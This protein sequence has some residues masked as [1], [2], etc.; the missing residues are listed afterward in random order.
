MA[1]LLDVYAAFGEARRFCHG[2]KITLGQAA[3][4]ITLMD[5]TLD[6]EP[7]VAFTQTFA[8]AHLGLQVATLTRP[9]ANMVAAGWL[10]KIPQMVD[11]RAK[12]YRLTPQGIALAL[13]LRDWSADG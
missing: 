11:R 10:K 9:L 3:I 8:A 6:K 12:E 7:N 1:D 5:S 13:T 4:L 2:Y